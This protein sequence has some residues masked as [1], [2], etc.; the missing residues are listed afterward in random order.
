M[1]LLFV[2]E[3]F[4]ALGGAEANVL[5]TAGEL[6]RRGHSVAL[7]HGPHT[8]R[9]EDAWRETFTDCYSLATAQPRAAL[10]TAIDEFWPD[11]IFLH[12][13]ADL[14][15]VEALTTFEVPV[16]RMVH[17]HDL[18]CMRGYK[19]N[20]L[21]RQVCT[22]AASAFCVFPCGGSIARN[23]AG[24]FPLAWVSYAAKRREIELNQRFRRLIVASAFMKEE[25]L[26]NG[27]GP[28]QIEIHAPVPRSTEQSF[29]CTLGPRNR[30]VYA[31]QIVRGKGVDILLESLARVTTPFECVILGDGHHRPYCE[32]LSHRLG[33]A[34]RVRFTGYIPAAEIGAYYASATLAVFSSVWPEPFGLSGL[35]ALRHGLP[36][37]AFDVGGVREWLDDGVNGLLA[38]WMDRAAFAAQVEKLLLDPALARRLGAQGRALAAGR[39]D[40]A[41][42]VDGLEHLF[43]T[44]DATAPVEVL[45]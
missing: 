6:K 18:Y 15:L 32:E 27:F 12:K 20:P 26:R 10:R 1:R 13:L 2:H 31:G 39:F 24:G 41:R 22:R 36:V 30:I 35:E 45:G 40:F 14:D 21:T 16:V 29:R 42:Y 38:P 5:A 4:G 43:G 33:L 19:Y 7:A 34:D 17:D 3:K 23:S 11:V 25:L 44:L 28:A 37:V 8:G 9:E